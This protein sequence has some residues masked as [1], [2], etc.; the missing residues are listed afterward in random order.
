MIRERLSKFL[1]Y[2]GAT[3]KIKQSLLAS[4][5]LFGMST[6]S[7]LSANSIKK[8]DSLYDLAVIGGG[9]GGLA[10]AF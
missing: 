7:N 4:L 2:S 10:A 9:S 6:I 8:Y 3:R 5:P 1:T